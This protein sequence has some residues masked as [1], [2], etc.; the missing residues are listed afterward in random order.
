M[1]LKSILTDDHKRLL[2]EA[3]TESNDAASVFHA[4]GLLGRDVQD[5]LAR[6]QHCNQMV[7]DVMEYDRQYSNGNKR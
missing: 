4:A 6:C 5:A 1:P 3:V 2:R 7:E